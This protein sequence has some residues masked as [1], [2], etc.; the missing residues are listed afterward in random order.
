MPKVALHIVTWNGMKYLPL[1]FES[2]RNQTFTDYTI[3]IFDNGS[4]DGT[5]DFLSAAGYLFESNKDNIGFSGGHNALFN[6]ALHNS[7]EYAPYILLINQD[8]YLAP[9]YIE[10]LVLTLERYPRAGIASGLLLQWE[11]CAIAPSFGNI[12]V[13]TIDSAGIG[14]AR[15]RRAFEIN[16]GMPHV[17][18]V[19]AIQDVRHVFGVSC[20]LPLIRL[21]ALITVADEGSVFD[22]EFQSYK[23]DVDLCY[24]LQSAGFDAVV[25]YSTYAFHDRG[26]GILDKRATRTLSVRKNSYRNHLITLLKNEYS[27]NF[28]KDALWIICFEI[29]KFV[30]LIFC[31]P[32]VLASWIDIIRRM[33]RILHI[34][35]R[36]NLKRKKT[37]KEMRQLFIL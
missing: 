30:Y 11:N 37:A 31:E 5:Q 36:I 6:A 16:A 15:S 12:C 9:H 7:H 3:R 1:C 14:I 17:M 26:T 35:R 8:T 25:D 4:T 2:L 20:T 22:S 21:S 23:E 13:T 19:A 29:G 18:G 27:E 10:R 28:F 34:R 32:R 33:R 24:R